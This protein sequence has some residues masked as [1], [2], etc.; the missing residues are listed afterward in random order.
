M[1]TIIRK[2][3]Q[4]TQFSQ[5]PVILTEVVLYQPV[6]QK[7]G[8][9]T[10][11]TVCLWLE[12]LTSHQKFAGFII[13]WSI[14][15][16]NRSSIS[17]YLFLIIMCISS[18]FPTLGTLGCSG[19]FEYNFHLKFL[20]NKGALCRHCP[21]PWGIDG[22]HKQVTFS[23]VFNFYKKTGTNFILHV[24]MKILAINSVS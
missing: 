17:S 15:L 2:L 18:T 7:V 23:A 5:F 16:D 21:T 19:D 10:P 24:N 8:G 20:G 22:H 13:C 9:H 14:E 6:D 12:H 4:V 3:K 11:H 1:F